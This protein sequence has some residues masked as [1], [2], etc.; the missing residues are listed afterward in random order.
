MALSDTCCDALNDLQDDFIHYS[1]WGYSPKQLS[2]ITKAMYELSSFII[3]QDVPSTLKGFNLEKIIDSMVIDQLLKKANSS[4][5]KD[6]SKILAEVA[7]YH[8][9]LDKGIRTIFSQIPS[10]QYMTEVQ[11]PISPYVQLDIINRITNF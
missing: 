7:E 4:G 2:K 5:N 11:H 1:K 10:E 8:P 6:F 3:K 9:R